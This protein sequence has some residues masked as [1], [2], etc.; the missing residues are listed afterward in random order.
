MQATF[1]SFFAEEAAAGLAEEAGFAP[2]VL[3]H[4]AAR[5]IIPN[6]DTMDTAFTQ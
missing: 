2:P 1:S 6:T 3:P 4:P 5:L